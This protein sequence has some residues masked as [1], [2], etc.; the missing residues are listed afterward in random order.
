MTV[1]GAHEDTACQVGVH[2]KAPPVVGQGR[3]VAWA[4]SVTWPMVASENLQACDATTDS[5]GGPH[6]L[7]GARSAGLGIHREA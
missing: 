5:A 4:C 6:A 3:V 1:M 7:R 2:E